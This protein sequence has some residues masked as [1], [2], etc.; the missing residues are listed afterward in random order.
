VN[1]GVRLYVKAGIRGDFFKE[2]RHSFSYVVVP[3]NLRD[4]ETVRLVYERS[5]E[6][7][8]VW[9]EIGDAV[10]VDVEKNGEIDLGFA[11][12][13]CV[14]EPVE[15]VVRGRSRTDPLSERICDAIVVMWSC[16]K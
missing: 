12:K 7:Y 6:E 3:C 15:V 1:G 16:C 2:P 14:G 11:Q 4:E 10:Y 13:L 8:C 9:I 5:R